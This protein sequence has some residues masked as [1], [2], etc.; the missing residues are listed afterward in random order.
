MIRRKQKI[1]PLD[2]R[3]REVIYYSAEPLV[4]EILAVVAGMPIDL[5]RT[6]LE[7]VAA[8]SNHTVDGVSAPTRLQ[9]VG[10]SRTA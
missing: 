6:T 10:T 2:S 9:T 4:F 1:I 8:I 3:T 7:V 5:R